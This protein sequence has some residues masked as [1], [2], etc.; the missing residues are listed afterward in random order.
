M[1][2]ALPLLQ[3]FGGL[4]FS[5]QASLLAKGLVAKVGG[6]VCVCVFFFFF[7]FFFFLRGVFLVGG[8]GSFG[9]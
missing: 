3:G 5:A 9:G 2:Q 1:S 8:D 7:F 6:V 4:G